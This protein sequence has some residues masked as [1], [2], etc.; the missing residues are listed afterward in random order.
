MRFFGILKLWR[1]WQ[2]AFVQIAQRCIWSG[3]KPRKYWGSLTVCEGVSLIWLS[4]LKEMSFP[5]CMWGCIVNDGMIKIAVDVPSLYV[6]VYLWLHSCRGWAGCSLTV[7]EGVSRH[8]ISAEHFF[9]F[10]HCMWGC[11]ASVYA[12]LRFF[13]VPSLYVRVYRAYTRRTPKPPRSLTVCEGVSH[14]RS[15]QPE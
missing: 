10:P 4:C 1:G 6:R 11:I 7:C 5:H 2:K 13:C 9:R 8:F 3:W 12:G 15:I 14:A